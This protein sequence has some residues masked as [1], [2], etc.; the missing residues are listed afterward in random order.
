[1]LRKARE[2]AS[3]NGTVS[4][5]VF[6]ASAF[7]IYARPYY[8]GIEASVGKAIHWRD[9]VFLSSKGVFS[10]WFTP[11]RVE[12]LCKMAGYKEFEILSGEDLA[13]VVRSKSYVDIKEQERFKRRAIF[14]IARV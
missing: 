14:V 12:T 13:S 2:L 11:D 4:I 5:S 9:S 10:L 1:M 7:D 8:T 6:N 3:P